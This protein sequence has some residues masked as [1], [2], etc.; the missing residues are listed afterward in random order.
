M[1]KYTEHYLL[2]FVLYFEL[3]L[4]DSYWVDQSLLPLTQNLS[5]D[6]QIAQVFGQRLEQQVW[7]LF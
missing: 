7:D 2:N 5:L 4:A 6:W 3:D 1:I